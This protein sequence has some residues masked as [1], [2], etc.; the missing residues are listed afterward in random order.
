MAAKGLYVVI[1][2]HKI[3]DTLPDSLLFPNKPC[4]QRYHCIQTISLLYIN[5]TNIM[6]LFY[7]LTLMKNNSTDAIMLI[8]FMT[9]TKIFKSELG[10]KCYVI[11]DFL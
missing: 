3:E 9:S 6:L 7:I 1:V 10:R 11:S 2:E 5:K 8:F 4:V